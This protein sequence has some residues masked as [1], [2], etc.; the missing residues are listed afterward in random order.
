MTKQM[1]TIFDAETGAEITR[2]MN[3]TELAQYEEDQI[4]AANYIA[5]MEAKAN[6]KAAL[7]DRLGITAEEAALLLG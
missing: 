4:T 6:A 1:I 2:E 3:E 5:E 7:L